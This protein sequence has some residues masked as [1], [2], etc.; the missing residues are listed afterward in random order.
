[1]NAVHGLAQVNF[2]NMKITYLVSLTDQAMDSRNSQYFLKL[3]KITSYNGN[4]WSQKD[5]K[6][7]KCKI[8]YKK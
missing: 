7:A 6:Y 3:L 2:S 5:Q 8:I 4:Y 1:M